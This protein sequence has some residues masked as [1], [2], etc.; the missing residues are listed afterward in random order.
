MK[1]RILCFLLALISLLSVL[2][3]PL[4]AAGSVS[5]ELRD[6]AKTEVDED[7]IGSTYKKTS[8]SPGVK[9]ESKSD[10]VEAFPKEDGG[11]PSIIEVMEVGYTAS[12][13]VYSAI[14]LYLWIYIPDPDF[15]PTSAS[16]KVTLADSFDFNPLDKGVEKADK[17]V[18]ES[19]SQYGLRHIGTSSSGTVYKFAIDGFD[20]AGCINNGQRRYNISRFDLHYSGSS[21]AQNYTAGRTYV[22]TGEHANQTYSASANGLDVLEIKD[23]YQTCFRYDNLQD[24]GEVDLETQINTVF[25]SI[26]ATYG[27]LYDDIFSIKTDWRR[28]RSSP[29]IVT[30]DQSFFDGLKNWILKPLSADL[31]QEKPDYSF[32]L[33]S[34]HVCSI[35][36]MGV[37]INNYLYDYSYNGIDGYENLENVVSPDSDAKSI[38]PLFWLFGFKGPDG[39]WGNDDI[40]DAYVRSSYVS[41]WYDALVAAGMDAD[42]QHL[43]TNGVISRASLP[44]GYGHQSL[45]I[46]AS[47][48]MDSFLTGYDYSSWWEKFCD[49]FLGQAQDAE[50]L[51]GINAIQKIALN[52]DL[53]GMSNEAISK[54]YLIACEEV[55][56]FKEYCKTE[57]SVGNTVVVL[58]YASSV[59]ESYPVAVKLPNGVVSNSMAYAAIQDIFLDFTVIEMTFEKDGERVVISVSSENQNVMGPTTPP[60]GGGSG[61]DD[62]KTSDPW[63]ELIAKLE[64]FLDAVKRILLWI[65]GIVAIVLLVYLLSVLMK[66]AGAV[67]DYLSAA[68]DNA[69]RRREE[70]Q[71]ERERRDKYKNNQNN[72]KKNTNRKHKKKWKK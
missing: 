5:T 65:L 1:K 36:P 6:F 52:S 29:M 46:L 57:T 4:S 14:T 3:L 31:N 64:A 37:P 47:D 70:K 50:S 7:L 39:V 26:P 33:Y 66:P 71:R 55:D 15:Q 16:N 10:V 62:T 69:R 8:L 11:E 32:W 21:T 12:K 27:V 34:K 13:G 20:A 49:W 35:P 40:E 38:N 53:S 44:G 61:I 30:T 63:G 45:K 23:L 28:Y 60:G 9:I 2:I 22:C 43:I 19:Y 51:K 25:F 48:S 18:A 72:T 59:Y 54:K 67:I 68:A 42:Y 56:V 41:A 17:W 24:E 58:H